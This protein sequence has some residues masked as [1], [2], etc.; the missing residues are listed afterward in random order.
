MNKAN[1]ISVPPSMEGVDRPDL[2]K[3]SSWP[4]ET[5]VEN[6]LK[7][8]TQ[9]EKLGQ[10]N[11]LYPGEN[12]DEAAKY[13][14]LMR[15]GGVSSYIWPYINPA[16]RNQF[17]RVAVQESRLGIPIIFGQDI[18]HGAYTLF[19]ITLGLACSFDPELLERA[20]TVA[21]RESRAEGIDWVFAPMCDLA[22]DPRWGRVAETCGEDPYLSALCNAA[23]VRGFQGT[24]PAAPDRVASCLKH[25]VGYS[26]VTGGRDYNDSEITE[27]TLRNMH[28]PAFHAGVKAGALSIMSSFNSVEGIPAVANHHTL[29]EVLRGEW[30]FNG[31]VVSD[32][33]AVT[34]M[35]PWGYARDNADAARL[36]ISAGNDMDMKSEA[37]ASHLAQEVKS[38]RLSQATVDEAVR[39]VLRVKFQTGL[40]DRPYVDESGFK[41]AQMKPADLALARECVAKSTVLLKNTGILPLSKELKKVALIGPLGDDHSEIL[42]CWKGRCTWSDM[43]LA[44]GLK[45]A[46]PR[47]TVLTVVKGCSI[48]T[49]ASMMTLQDGSVVPDENAQPTDADLKIDAAVLAAQDADVVIMAVG[50]PKGW[51]GENG[52]RAFLTLTG[53]QQA[54]FDAVAAVGKP[55]VTIVFSGRP[56]A[57]PEVWDNSAAVFYAWQPGIGAGQGLADLLVG[58]VAPSARLSMSVP[59]DV[60]QVPIF[61]NYPNTGRPGSGQYRDMASTDAKFWFGYGL[62]YTMFDYS[63]VR[64]IPAAKGKPAEAVVTLTN[65]GKREGVEVV[66]LYIGQLACHEGVRPKQEL[67]GFKHVKL[68]PGERTDVCFPLSVE[69]LGYIDRKGNARVDAGEYQVWVA[70]R[71]HYGTPVKFVN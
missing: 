4:V 64:I 8:M 41:S 66:Q 44:T 24:N 55:V 61:Y 7:Q 32:W 23:Q 50:E 17:Q 63:P 21:A 12:E 52:S 31:F 53:H 30:K 39:R 26:A 49:S 15:R 36:A 9:E 33:D 20:Q 48:N 25:Y 69:V 14:P 37:Y 38:E 16:L 51:T 65:T 6:L 13:L 22:R 47:D 57:L 19:P 28:L 67:R 59:R 5:R 46:L 62:T 56:L 45:E 29:T 1:V 60:A 10:L 11:Q 35:I 70:P 54:L 68:Q 42:G 2:Y 34:E 27:W 18:I 58:N 43:T 71:S 40:F 3:N